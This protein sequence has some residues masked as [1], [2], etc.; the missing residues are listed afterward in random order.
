MRRH[1][2]SYRLVLFYIYTHIHICRTNTYVTIT[3]SYNYC[4]ISYDVFWVFLSAVVLTS[5]RRT[6]CCRAGG[7]VV[8]SSGDPCCFNLVCKCSNNC[9]ALS[10]LNCFCYPDSLLLFFVF[11]ARDS[12]H[13]THNKQ[14]GAESRSTRADRC[15]A[16]YPSRQGI[17]R[18]GEVGPY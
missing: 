13:R 18:E 9:Y 7:C 8:A 11:S 14:V 3:A 17:F 12:R 5:Q 10:S 4:I 1:L 15:G 6:P 2:L 16:A